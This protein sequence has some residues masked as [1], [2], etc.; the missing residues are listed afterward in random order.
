MAAIVVRGLDDSVKERLSAQAK[1][2]GHSM[3]AEAREILTSAVQNPNIGIALLNLAQSVDEG[4]ELEIPSRN[5]VARA[6]D[7][8]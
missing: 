6:A 2:R 8:G 1:R 3:E 7:F 4:A 5:D